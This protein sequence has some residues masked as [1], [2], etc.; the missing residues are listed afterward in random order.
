MAITSLPPADYGAIPTAPSAGD[1]YQSVAVYSDIQTAALPSLTPIGYCNKP[2]IFLSEAA[3][4]Y[5]PKNCYEDSDSYQIRLSTALSSFQPFYRSLKDLTI[6]TALRKPISLSDEQSTEEWESFFRNSTLEGD[7]ITVF[8]KRLLAAS[9]DSG[10]AG[11]L[12][13]F[14]RTETAEN[15]A[16]ER[17]QKLRPYFQIIN[18]ADILG[19]KSEIA[20]T[21]IGE[22]TEYG[23]RLTQLR[24]KDSVSESDPLDEFVEI[25]RPAVHV[26]DQP[27]AEEPVRHRLFVQKP[28]SLNSPDKW[29]LEEETLLSIPFIPFVPCYANTCDG[30]MRA[31]P[32]LLDIARLNLKH[33]QVSS[34][35]AHS[36]HLTSTPS[37]VIA[38]VNAVG[39]NGDLQVSPDRSLILADPASRADWIG[40]PSDGAD[41]MRECLKDLEH[42]MMTL[43]P[44]QKQDKATTGVESAAAKKIDRAQSDAVLSLLV[45]NLEDALNQALAIAAVYWNTPPVMLDLPRDFVPE[46]MTAPEIKEYAALVATNLISHETF[47]RKLQVSEVF[48][49]L[50]NWTVEEELELLVESETTVDPL[51]LPEEEIP[52]QTDKVETNNQE[53]FSKDDPDAVNKTQDQPFA[54]SDS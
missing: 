10:L 20:T 34:D 32:L 43:S 25:T 5:I 15:L 3:E 50:D 40:A 21:Q 14:P 1:P 12:I 41:V 44:V 18:F 11:I 26:F 39:E 47:L 17:A 24:I 31:R 45:S 6:G 23:N 2:E 38:G 8:A 53:D 51:F 16:Q 29:C 4:E 52:D 37:L 33:W 13:D 35:L 46:A 48:D 22:T 49:G 54:N 28:L 9:I 7:S 42:A 30:F 27:S 36:L 19:W